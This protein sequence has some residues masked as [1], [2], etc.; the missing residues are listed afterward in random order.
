MDKLGFSILWRSWIKG[1]LGNARTSILVNGSLTNEFEISKGLRQGD[2]LSPLLFI[3]AMEGLHAFICKAVDLGIYIGVHVGDNNLCLSY[4]IYADDVIFIGDWSYNNAHNLLCVCVSDD[5]VSTKANALGCGAAKMPLKYLG[6]PVGC[7]MGRCSNWDAI[8]QKN[9]SKLTQLVGGHL[10]LIKSV[11]GSLPTYYMSLYKVHVSICN[12]L[13]SMRNNFFIDGDL[14]V[15]KLACVSWKKCMASKKRGG[16]GIGN[17]HVLNAGLLFKW[18]EVS[19]SEEPL[20][21]WA[22]VLY[23]GDTLGKMKVS[24]RLSSPF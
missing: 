4:L 2:P 3:L 12:K 5:I 10:S 24:L 13:E 20:D 15:K 21:L 1:C 8:V 6:V 23:K 11:L 22:C 17:I 7:N 14:G 9:Y 18:L 16:L 19:Y